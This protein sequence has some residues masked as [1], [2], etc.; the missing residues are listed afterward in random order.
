VGTLQIFGVERE[1]ALSFAFAVHALTFVPLTLIGIFYMMRE[2][3]SLQRIEQ[4]A[5]AKPGG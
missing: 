2:N 4:E 5:L 3:Y 1:L